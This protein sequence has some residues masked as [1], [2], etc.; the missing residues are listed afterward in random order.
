MK[1]KTLIILNLSLLIASCTPK[2]IPEI[3]VEEVVSHISYLASDSLKGRYPGTTGDSLTLHYVAENFKNAGLKNF[4]QDYI[5]VFDYLSGIAPSE[6]N[7][8]IFSEYRFEQEKDFYPMSFSAG[9]SFEAPVIFCGYGFEF[10]TEE[11]HHD[12]YSS[13]NPE[14]HWAI[15]LRGEPREH[16]DYIERSGDRD[17]ALLAQDKGAK[18]VVLVSGTEFSTADELDN[19]IKREPEIDIP[20]IQ[21]TREAANA[22][23]KSSGYT[24]EEL[25]KQSKEEN[26]T[27]IS[28]SQKLGAE[29][30]LEKVYTST[31][32]VIA[33]VTGDD[34]KNGNWIVVGAH[35][36]HLGMGGEGN[37]S[38]APDTIAVHNGAD[39]NASG[40]AAIIELAE[41]FSY[42][43]NKPSKNII[44]V[45]FGAEEKGILGS[46]HF[47]ENPPVD[48]KKIS[49]M[50]NI[51]MLG[52]MKKDSGLQVGGVGTF[53]DSKEIITSINDNYGLKLSYSE[54]G[55]GPSDHASFYASNIP[56]L[57]FS[58][59]AHSDYHTPFDDPDSLNYEGLA[60]GTRFISDIIG[61]VDSRENPIVFQEAGPKRR[62][63][64]SFRNM[65]TL[66]IM[67]D[68]SGSGENGMKVLAVTDGKPADLG[69]MK[70]GDLITAID[71]EKVDNVYDYMYRLKQLKAGQPIVVTVRR[72]NE[73]IDLLIHL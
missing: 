56:V 21:L 63:S 11:I 29:L 7:Y 40:V 6:K 59:G 60:L 62:S 10:K 26:S 27:G 22:I 57:F 9:G 20:V 65:V 35:H 48:L 52:R 61:K 33:Y 53:N 17:K 50:V 66:G 28:T 69:G 46:R 41:F 42:G 51:D 43:K 32:N 55:Y 37:S 39:D 4:N 12:D 19:S 16:D 1:Y 3:T 18:G 24:I 49:L 70:K 54:A 58:T 71:G 25:E 23:L 44:F 2:M 68:V 5:Q 45:T 30:K 47:V 34:E 72:N 14:G 64:R 36:D 73:E 38:R 31:A 15:I 8:L 13:V 67:P